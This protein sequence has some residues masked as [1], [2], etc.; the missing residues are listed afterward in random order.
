[1][2]QDETSS[3]SVL[4]FAKFAAQV[5]YKHGF[6]EG[7]WEGRVEQAVKTILLVLLAH[8]DL[9]QEEVRDRIVDQL[10]IW[11]CR[12]VTAETVDEIFD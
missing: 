9:P 1:M 12:A 2:E 10:E 6:Y 4:E 3:T 11:A 7:Y 8:R 5:H